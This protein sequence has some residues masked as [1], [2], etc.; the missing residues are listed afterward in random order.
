MRIG[1][2]LVVVGALLAGCGGSKTAEPV[3]IGSDRNDYKQ[4]PC[5][6]GPVLY[7]NGAWLS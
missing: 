5:A 1:L 3:G 7:R 6:C 2:V 4:S